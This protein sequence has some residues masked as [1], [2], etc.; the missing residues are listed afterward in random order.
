MECNSEN[1]LKSLKCNDFFTKDQIKKSDEMVNINE[2]SNSNEEPSNPETLMDFLL[3]LNKSH[4]LTPEL[5]ENYR[6]K[7]LDFYLDKDIST[8]FY[9]NCRISKIFLE[10]NDGILIVFDEKTEEVELTKQKTKII[11]SISHNLRNPVYGILSQIECSLIEC[12]DQK[13]KETLT[14][15]KNCTQILNLLLNDFFDYSEILLKKIEPFFSAFE[16][17]GVVDSVVHLLNFQAKNKN[18]RIV[19]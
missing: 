5:H 11:E 15:A 13:L 3:F 12:H 10:G 14:I 16:L 8:R 17:K 2:G 6:I 18:L 9:F 19:T 7:Q 1:L 4:D